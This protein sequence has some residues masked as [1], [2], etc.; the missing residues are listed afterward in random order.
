MNKTTAYIA[1]GSN[2]GN[3]EQTIRQALEHLSTHPQVQL[4]SSSTLI[5]TAAQ[6][7]AETQPDF[8]NGA[9]R[10]T[11]ALAADQ[12]LDL[13]QQI[14]KSLGRVRQEKWGPRTIDLDLLLFG[15]DIIETPQ[16]KVPHPL[17]HTRRF[18]LEP[19]A[20]IAPEV[21]H[22]Q[23]HKTIPHLLDQ[24]ETA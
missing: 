4:E 1:L 21:V 10:I 20:E 6:G 11:T 7:G 18:V 13:L 3:R 5:T 17:M 16:L 2:L 24:L 9:A 12:L 15:N 14:E 8:L 22:P 23:L 19:L